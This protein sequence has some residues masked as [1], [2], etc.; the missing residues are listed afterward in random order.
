MSEE[1]GAQGEQP[2][3]DV[4]AEYAELRA[5]RPISRDEDGPWRVARYE[6]RTYDLS[7]LESLWYG[8]S[9]FFDYGLA[10]TL[11]SF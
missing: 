2:I 3:E 4:Y 1:S 7:K 5:S 8:I 11:T 9:H 6:D 10:H